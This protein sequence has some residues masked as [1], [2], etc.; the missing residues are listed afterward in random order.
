MHIPI[1]SKLIIIRQLRRASRRAI[2]GVSRNL[3]TAAVYVAYT[4]EQGE[5]LADDAAATAHAISAQNARQASGS[6]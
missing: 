6:P 2:L 1:G 5:I 4:D 3:Q